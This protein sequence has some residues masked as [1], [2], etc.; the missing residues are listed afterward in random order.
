MALEEF[1]QSGITIHV[2]RMKVRLV[3][4]EMAGI[5]T[6]TLWSTVKWLP[7]DNNTSVYF[8]DTF[9]YF[10]YDIHTACALYD[11]THSC[12]VILQILVQFTQYWF[13]TFNYMYAR[14]FKVQFEIIP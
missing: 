5:W 7:L 13:N 9:K 4:L 8:L 1:V 12:A 11:I 2:N 10:V 6:C 3:L 14:L